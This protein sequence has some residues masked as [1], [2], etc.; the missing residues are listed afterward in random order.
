MPFS[1]VCVMI[2]TI[3]SNRHENRMG[4]EIE[5]SIVTMNFLRRLTA[6]HVHDHESYSKWEYS[7]VYSRERGGLQQCGKYCGA[8]K[9]YLTSASH[10]I[11]M[12]DSLEF[13]LRTLSSPMISPN[14][15]KNIILVASDEVHF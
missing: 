12:T 14:L 6:R 5:W 7:R 11:L 13:R 3:T 1:V 15:S 2:L 4:S 9:S 10:A 8:Q